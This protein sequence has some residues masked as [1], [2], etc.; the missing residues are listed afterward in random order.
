MKPTH[1]YV[2]R[3]LGISRVA[4]PIL[5]CALL[6][7]CLLGY[8]LVQEHTR[9]TQTNN[10]AH[11]HL[12]KILIKQASQSRSGFSIASTDQQFKS[13]PDMWTGFQGWLAANGSRSGH[14]NFSVLDAEL[15]YRMQCT[16]SQHPKQKPAAKAEVGAMPL[17]LTPGP[18][19]R[20]LRQAKTETK[21][22]TEQDVSHR[23]NVQG[24]VDT[25]QGRKHFDAEH[26]RWTR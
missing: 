14:C 13:E 5:D 12:S 26:K 18:I 23:Y 19:E 7:L 2:L 11:L 20:P 10:R 8:V 1:P 17:V 9:E 4:R 22:L 24:W 15:P 21:L 16:G 3:L 25:A 6:A